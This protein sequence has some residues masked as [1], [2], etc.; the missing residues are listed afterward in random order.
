MNIWKRLLFIVPPVAS[1]LMLKTFFLLA[2]PIYGCTGVGSGLDS[3]TPSLQKTFI[4]FG[5]MINN[6]AYVISFD[7][8]YQLAI[9]LWLLTILPLALY[10]F[11]RK[12]VFVASIVALL[13]MVLLIPLTITLVQLPRAL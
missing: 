1:T 3:C 5:E 8:L 6:F 7:H 4:H 2:Q 12:A 9:T 11:A 13:A 10:L